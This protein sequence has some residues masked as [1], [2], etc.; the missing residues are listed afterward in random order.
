LP[1]MLEHRGG[2][3]DLPAGGRARLEVAH[4]FAAIQYSILSRIRSV[5]LAATT[6]NAGKQTLLAAR[7][8]ANRMGLA[9]YLLRPDFAAGFHLVPQ[10]LPLHTSFWFLSGGREVPLTHMSSREVGTR[11]A[12]SLEVTPLAIRD[13]RRLARTVRASSC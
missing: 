5:G 1:P 11:H 6:C 12:P 8:T 7:A 3:Y 4:V 2:G 13:Q 10:L 9:K